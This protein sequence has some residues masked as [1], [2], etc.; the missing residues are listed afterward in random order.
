MNAPGMSFAAWFHSHKIRVFPLHTRSKI[1]AVKSWDDYICTHAEAS[2]FTDYG[3]ALGSFG[4]ADSDDE[5]SEAFALAELPETPF[6]VR[7]ARGVHR[8]YRLLDP[9][10]TPNFIHRGTMTMEFRNAGQYVVGPGSTHKTGTVYTAD[11]WS[12]KVTDVPFFPV[13]EFVWDTRDA[14]ERGS[15]ANSANSTYQLPNKIY[16]GERHDQMFRIMRSLRMRGISKAAAIRATLLENQH[17]CEPPLPEGVVRR[18]LNRTYEHSDRKGF[19]PRRPGVNAALRVA[20]DLQEDGF[21]E[22]ACIEAALDIDPKLNERDPLHEAT[23][24]PANN[25]TDVRVDR[26]NK[27]LADYPHITNPEDYTLSKAGY[28]VMRKGAK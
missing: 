23:V 16:A 11:D 24:E 20:S 27:R 10:R 26:Y 2:R 21:C 19:I 14:G 22:E 9:E 15:T 12:W 8:Y 28:W 6:I 18:F 1:P 7:T 17:H 4:V 3:V 5:Q 25:F 13:D